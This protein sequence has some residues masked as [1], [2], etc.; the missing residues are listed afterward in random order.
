MIY[1]MVGWSFESK[2]GL[3]FVLL[4]KSGPELANLTLLLSITS[5]NRNIHIAYADLMFAIS[6]EHDTN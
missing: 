3:E 5:L 6:K 1:K 4:T 2:S